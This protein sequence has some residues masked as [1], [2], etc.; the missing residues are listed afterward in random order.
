MSEIALGVAV[1]AT[2]AV[3]YLL[4]RRRVVGLTPQFAATQILETMKSAVI[5]VDME[6][7]IRVANRA[8]TLLL[9]YEAGDLIGQP[10]RII[11]DADEDPSTRR[12]LTSTGILEQQMGWRSAAGIRVDVLTSS[13]FVRAADGAPVGVVYVASD[14]TE[15]K[16]AD[17][18]L[19]ESEARY[20]LLFERNLAGV[21][22]TSVD[23]RVLDCN[24]AFARIFGYAS[25]EEM[26]R[27]GTH[28][29]Y[30]DH[31]DRERI[32]AL[33]RE[34]TSLTNHEARM[35]RKNDTAVWVL[36]NMTLLDGVVEGTVIDITDRK[37]A[38]E[39]VE[40][41]AYHD[42]LTAL[43]N[44]LLFRDRLS[45]A[46]A[47]ARRYSQSVAVMFI[48]LDEFKTVND[49]LGHTVGD[50]LLQAIASRLIA[51]VRA[52]DTVARLGGDEFTILLPDAG[53][54]RGAA[55]VARKILTSVAEP[56]MV[57]EHRLRIT[58][59]IGIALFPGDGFDADTLLKNADRA[60][61]RAKQMGRNNYQYAT[62]PPFDDRVSIQRRISEALARDQF[63]LH[64]QAIVGVATGTV[65][66][67][68]ALIRW[69]DPERGLQ[70][71][72]SFL[73]LAEDSD[74]VIQLGEWVLR[75]AC[76]QMKRWHERGFG[77]L[78]ICVNLSPRQFSQREV[79]DSISRI[80][81]DSRL[82]PEALE[83]EITESTAMNNPELSL[84]TMRRLKQTGIR[85]AIDDFGT[86]YSSFRYLRRLP[87]DTVKVDHELVR[88]L[89]VDEGDRSTMSAVISMARALD[90]R[91]VAE[92]VETAE[93]LEV[94][95]EEGCAEMQGFF[96]SRPMSAA[97][98]ER[99]VL[100][101]EVDRPRAEAPVSRGLE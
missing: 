50:R 97:D 89:A 19:R 58:P 22:R 31:E 52:D 10:M 41:Q 51:S 1:F 16:R 12:I 18:R 32:L 48:D 88:N 60:M 38:E 20:R 57:D 35:R 98:L 8:A 3:V 78:R 47:H 33:L 56:V 95:R 25:R 44:R 65:V 5:L 71:P 13:S 99:T 67:V 24:E 73:G 66:A 64:Y 11:F 17:R 75:T 81:Q 59:S 21:Y 82:P 6:G 63:V 77:S 61:Y 23:G 36:E 30:F 42:M 45:L 29:L 27:H 26:L 7:K 85:I 87:I 54:G 90:L 79:A 15:R 43:P 14:Y 55:T 93:Q 49:S 46:L 84:L 101:P 37:Y 39:Q 70:Q 76:S 92:G 34:Q 53:D 74:V 2:A 40:Y 91:V 96:H 68:E 100:T 9:G 4:R 28:A 69:N 80:L 72:D 83:I 94:L 86:G 62:P